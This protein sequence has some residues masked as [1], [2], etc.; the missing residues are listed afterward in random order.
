MSVL[1]RCGRSLGLIAYALAYKPRAI[2]LANIQRCFPEM[3]PTAQRRLCKDYF[4]QLGVGM[5]EFIIALW[6]RDR[7]LKPLLHIEGL[8]IFKQANATGR[9]VILLSG[10]F[11]SLE[12][13]IRLAG[14][15]GLPL[16]GVYRQLKNPWMNQLIYQH[17]KRSALELIERKNA[18]GLVKALKRGA[19][20]FYLPDMDMGKDFDA[21]YAPFFGTSVATVTA[22][23]KLAKITDAVVL[24]ISY[25]RLEN[26][27]GYQIT[28]HSELKNFPTEDLVADT[29]Q[30]NQTLETLINAKPQDYFWHQKRFKR[31]K[32]TL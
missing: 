19:A 11:T 10:H 30:V 25:C 26:D 22:T 4:R 18:R 23:S 17:R 32:P 27:K 15:A 5:M 21:V 13:I 29:T 16:H 28:I 14:L 2:A 7:S 6:W 9:G 20:V 3:L 24:P 8:D 1:L 31:V 12:L